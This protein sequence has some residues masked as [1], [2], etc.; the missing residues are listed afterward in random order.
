MNYIDILQFALVNPNRCDPCPGSSTIFP[1][2]VELK[3]ADTDLPPCWPLPPGPPCVA[4]EAARPSL[5]GPIASARKH[6]NVSNA[7]MKMGALPW[8][9]PLLAGSFRLRSVAGQGAVQEDKV[10]TALH[11][12]VTHGVETALGGTD[13]QTERRRKERGDRFGAELHNVLGFLTQMM[14]EQ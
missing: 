8:D 7:A 9:E 14:A 10:G 13:Q 5:T 12:P 4:N 11:N 6:G 2:P 3:G 1:T